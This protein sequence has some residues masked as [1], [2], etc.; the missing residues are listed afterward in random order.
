M[1]KI[2]EK[3]GYIFINKKPFDTYNAMIKKKVPLLYANAVLFFLLS[4]LDIEDKNN[5]EIEELIEKELFLTGTLSG[6]LAFIFSSLYSEDNKGKLKEKE[7]KGFEEFCSSPHTVKLSSTTY[8]YN[9]REGKCAVKLT[10]TFS[11]TD[12][13]KA[14]AL[15]H[16]ALK[17]NPFLSKK[18]LLEI[19]KYELQTTLDE[20]FDNFCQQY[21]EYPPEVEDYTWERLDDVFKEYGIEYTDWEF[22]YFSPY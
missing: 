8:W 18:D 5:F 21:E 4:N 11:V 16:L 19:L 6:D 2:I 14:F 22:S 15:F 12:R 10:F 7:Y 20:D 17:D 3:E 13:N 9:Q 1:N